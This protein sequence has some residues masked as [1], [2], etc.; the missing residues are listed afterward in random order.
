MKL[1]SWLILAI[2]AGASCLSKLL[3]NSNSLQELI[4]SFNNFG[5]DGIATIA[6]G[7]KYN[8]A[9]TKLSV[10]KCGFSVKGIVRRI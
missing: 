7:L 8:T 10:W 4:I 1:A 2:I 9:L 5:D 6:E 3:K